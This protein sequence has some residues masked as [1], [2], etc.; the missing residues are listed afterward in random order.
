LLLNPSDDLLNFEDKINSYG[1]FNNYSSTNFDYLLKKRQR[2]NSFEELINMFPILDKEVENN[3]ILMN[4]NCS[5]NDEDFKVIFQD[6]SKTE[7]S[8]VIS[9]NLEAKL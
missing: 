1:I 7:A 5:L 2:L 4:I 8:E 3:D 6:A 9:V